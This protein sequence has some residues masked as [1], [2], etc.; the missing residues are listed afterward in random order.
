MSEIE[1]DAAELVEAGGLPVVRLRPNKGKA[2]LGGHPWVYR[3]ELVL[4]R[5]T[6]SLT[7]GSIALLEDTK[8]VPVGIVAV[9]T[10]SGIAARELDRD[11]AAIIDAAWIEARL[12]RA[13]EVR[14]RMFSRPFYRLCHAEGDG[15][16]GV[17]IDRIDTT[18]VI[19]PNT[20]WAESVLEQIVGALDA[21]VAPETIV[22]NRDSRGRAQEGLE[23]GREVLRGLAPAEIAVQ[24]PVASVFADLGE[25]QKTGVYFDQFANHGIVAALAKGERVLDVF[26]HTGGFALSCLAAG[27]DHATVLDSSARALDLTEQA[28]AHGG[29]SDRLRAMKADAFDGLRELAAAQER[30]GIVICDPPAFAPRKASLEAGL[31]AYERVSTLALP[32]V[33]TGG[34]FVLCSCSHAVG[35]DAL[36]E[37]VSRSLHR[38]GRRARLFHSGGA[39]PDHPVHP[40]LPESGYLKML[41]YALD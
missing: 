28:A 29:M 5:R 24:G 14:T 30:F 11:R 2:F 7:P 37:T 22:I 23:G 10:G 41:A 38:L 27:A 12:A 39:G 35:P 15:L 31:R 13:L 26:S 16:P 18:L 33:A 19:Q 34:I 4:D 1:A 36:R 25:G 40:A 20:A 8:R 3:D 17:I 21:L 32:L 9:N 6:S